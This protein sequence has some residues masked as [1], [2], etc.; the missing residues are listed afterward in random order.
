MRT[1]TFTVDQILSM[2]RPQAYLEELA[3][4]ALS[5]TDE[6]MTFNPES[7]ALSY[8]QYE[9]DGDIGFYNGDSK[10][11]TLVFENGEFVEQKN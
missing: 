10:R 9:F 4:C 5:V 11:V 1:V 6:A 3:K 2:P 8:D 7:I